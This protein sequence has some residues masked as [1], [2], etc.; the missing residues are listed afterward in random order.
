MAASLIPAQ[1]PTF[2]DSIG[3]PYARVPLAHS[4]LACQPDSQ[5]DL[6]RV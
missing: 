3:I 2:R 5:D 6:C 1:R 4:A